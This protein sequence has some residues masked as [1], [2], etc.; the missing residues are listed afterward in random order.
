[1]CIHRTRVPNHLYDRLQGKLSRGAIISAINK[2]LCSQ[3]GNV[4]DP[5]LCSQALECAVGKM[6]T[7]QDIKAP[8]GLFV[9]LLKKEARETLKTQAPRKGAGTI[10]DALV[11]ILG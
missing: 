9:F 8:M 11:R 1:M 3:L 10:D 7:T 2:G 4:C 5:T 6:E